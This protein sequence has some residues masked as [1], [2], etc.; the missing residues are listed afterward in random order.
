MKTLSVVTL[1][2]VFLALCS[3]QGPTL[4]E[5]AARAKGPIVKAIGTEEPSRSVESLA[6]GANVIALGSVRPLK[7]YL[8]DDETLIYTDFV[9]TPLTLIARGGV[10]SQRTLEP[11]ETLVVKQVGGRMEM[12]GIQVTVVDEHLDALPSSESVLLFLEK[13]EKESKY[14]ILG[15]HWGAF[16]VRSGRVVPLV[17]PADAY[18]AYSGMDLDRFSE[19]VISLRALRPVK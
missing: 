13:I 10:G 4:R 8:S 9:F 14:R 5:I 19:E 7:T 6:A 12:G 11:G 18:H 17:K 15:E 16:A 3:A 1:S 2:A